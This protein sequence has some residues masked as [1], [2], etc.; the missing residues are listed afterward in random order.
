MKPGSSEDKYTALYDCFTG[1]PNTDYPDDL[2]IAQL[3]EEG[4]DDLDDKDFIVIGS[5]TMVIH[6]ANVPE[7]GGPVN[8]G[9]PFR[10][11]GV[12][13]FTQC[14]A[15]SHLG[16][17]MG[18]FAQA[19]TLNPDQPA[20]YQS[21]LQG[22]LKNFQESISNLRTDTGE[23]FSVTNFDFGWLT[24]LETEDPSGVYAKASD[25]IKPMFVYAAKAAHDFLVGHCSTTGEYSFSMEDVVDAFGLGKQ[26][27]DLDGY[28]DCPYF[29]VMMGTFCLVHLE[30]MSTMINDDADSPVEGYNFTY[31]A[32]L[33]GGQQSPYMLSKSPSPQFWPRAHRC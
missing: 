20:D 2:S 27:S 7:A 19:M 1:T 17:A 23:P 6:A 16:P 10:K 15:I 30:V 13:G 26:L 32:R 33:C 12:S 29:S 22:R 8:V 21:I 5:T 28:N 9:L 11:A 24:T 18:Y 31:R 14:T 4:A 3:L 25:L